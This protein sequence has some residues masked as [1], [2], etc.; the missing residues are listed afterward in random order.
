MTTPIICTVAT[1]IFQNEK[2]LKDAINSAYEA[3][4]LERAENYNPIKGTT[5]QYKYKVVSEEHLVNI[6]WEEGPVSK[7][8]QEAEE[9][10]KQIESLEQEEKNLKVEEEKEKRELEDAKRNTEQAKADQQWKCN[11]LIEKVKKGLEDKRKKKLDYYKARL[12]GQHPTH[13]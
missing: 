5:L 10:I 11:Q 8:E 9:V 2:F 1:K 12:S 13:Q 7:I 3:S 4:D 6:N